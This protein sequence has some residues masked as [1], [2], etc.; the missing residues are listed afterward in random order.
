[1]GVRT[2]EIRDGELEFVLNTDKSIA[3]FE[4]IQSIFKNEGTLRYDDLREGDLFATGCAI[5]GNM[6]LFLTYSSL[7][8]YENAYGIIPL[9]KWDEA[10]EEYYTVADAGCN[11][12]AVPVTTVNTELTGAMTEAMSAESW[13]TVMP[14]YCDICLGTKSA[15]DPESQEM[16]NLALD[17]RYIDFAYLYD[18]WSGWTFKMD[19]FVAKEGEFA[20][21]YKKNEKVV[22]EYYERVLKKFYG[23]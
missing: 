10:Q 5:F 23:E 3:V 12:L 11:V 8:D 20:S 2:T 19:A 13:R 1:M 7:R 21:K 15:R 22:R 18:G 9:P 14:T 17:S 4:K 6:R 16:I